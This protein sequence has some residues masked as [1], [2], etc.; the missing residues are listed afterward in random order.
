MV[1]KTRIL[2]GGSK[3]ALRRLLPAETGWK[4]LSFHEMFYSNSPEYLF[5][6][7]SSQTFDLHVHRTRNVFNLTNYP[8]QNG[9][10]WAGL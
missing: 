1:G 3:I 7:V 10:G 8:L 9:L 2:T 5:S 4:T 6:L